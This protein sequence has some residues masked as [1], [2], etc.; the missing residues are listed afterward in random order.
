MYKRKLLGFMTALFT[1]GLIVAM[2]AQASAATYGPGEIYM[3]SEAYGCMTVEGGSSADGARVIR[4]G[5]IGSHPAYQ[6]FYYEEISFN[7]G[8][9]WYH[10]KALHSGKCLEIAN[11]SVNTGAKLQQRTCTT[12]TLGKQVFAAYDNEYDDTYALYNENSL[13]CLQWGTTGSQVFQNSCAVGSPYQ[14]WFDW[15]SPLP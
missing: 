7:G 3:Y 8:V 14:G 15:F 11:G 12:S 6:R 1:I 13:K 4:S 10:I 2:P 5:C 9:T